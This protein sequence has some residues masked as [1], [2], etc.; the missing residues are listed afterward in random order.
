MRRGDQSC[1]RNPTD[2]RRRAA[3]IA[4]LAAALSGAAAA[5]NVL[6]NITMDR[7]STENGISAV[8]FPHWKHRSRFR[9]Y[10]C[11]PDIFEMQAGAND[12]NMSALSAG[13]FCGRCHDGRTAWAISF[14]TCRDCHSLE[15][16]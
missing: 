13:E 1:T 2:L 6:G 7:I 11:H 15:Q 3:L 8:V 9:C 16:M 12:I 14:E 10:A 5:P 4:L